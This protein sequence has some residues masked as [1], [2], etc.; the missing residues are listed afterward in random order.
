MRTFPWAITIC[1]RESA[2]W[3]SERMTIP[4]PLFPP[5]FAGGLAAGRT[6]AGARLFGAAVAGIHQLVA[7]V[8]ASNAIVHQR[9]GFFDLPVNVRLLFIGLQVIDASDSML[10]VARPLRRQRSFYSF[11]DPATTPLSS[12]FVDYT[13]TVYPPSAIPATSPSLDRM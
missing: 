9:R 13:P 3:T 10:D 1:A 4:P 7:Q 5:L 2:C 8:L 6:A 12:A 11:D